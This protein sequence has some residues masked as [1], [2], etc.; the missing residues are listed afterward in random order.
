MKKLFLL[1]LLLSFALAKS[2]TIDEAF[3]T[4]QWKATKAVVLN[5]KDKNKP[6]VKGLVDG[7]KNATYNFKKDHSFSFSSKS[8][9]KMMEQLIVLFNDNN[10]WVF[11]K[12]EKEIKVGRKSEG[13]STVA[14]KVRIENKKVIFLIED[15]GI[16]MVMKK[17]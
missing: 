15:A 13:Y 9:S 8:K 16:E 17:Q 12:K 14:F 2:Q 3:V 11:D 6:D 10:T 7:F 5:E 1:T 4:G